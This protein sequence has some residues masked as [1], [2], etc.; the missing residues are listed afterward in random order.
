MD[1]GHLRRH[2]LA[3]RNAL[4]HKQ[5]TAASQAITQKILTLPAFQT[6]KTIALYHA[7][8][9]EINLNALWHIAHQQGKTTCFPVIHADKT[10]QFLTF[11]TMSPET[12][13]TAYNAFQ[14]IDIASIDCFFVPLVA[15]DSRGYRIGLGKGYYDT[16][17][18]FFNEL[19]SEYKPPFMG[20]A[21]DFQQTME[22]IP[23]DPWDIKLDSVVT[24]TRFV[25]FI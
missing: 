5:Q 20:V 25:S 3:Q 24:E 15:F 16:T 6:A 2:I 17:L 13:S 18:A 21:Y 7:F 10:I 1:K 8:G 23:A 11:L 12:S 4:T 22:I 9:R 14:I 19:E